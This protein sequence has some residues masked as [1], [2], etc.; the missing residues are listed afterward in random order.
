MYV[1][2]SLLTTQAVSNM[3]SSNIFC[4]SVS[5]ENNDFNFIVRLHYW[6]TQTCH[7]V[8]VK[9]NQSIKFLYYTKEIYGIKT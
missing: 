6:L 2:G 4:F 8:C 5:I 7:Y 9:L 1:I 3:F